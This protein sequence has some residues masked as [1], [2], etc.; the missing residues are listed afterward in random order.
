MNTRLYVRLHRE[1]CVPGARCAWILRDSRGGEL[2]R[3]ESVLTALPAADTV[4]GVLAQDLVLV[5]AVVL[6]PGRR[7]RTAAALASAIE[8]HVLSDPASNHVVVLREARDGSTVLAAMARN[9]LDACLASLGDARRP[10]AKLVLESSLVPRTLQC[11]V[12]VCRADGGFLCLPDEQAVTLDAAADGVLPEGLKWHLQ[13]TV[14]A[15]RP[16]LL[17]VH[18][19][20]QA[21]DVAAW[22]AALG[23]DVERADA[24]DWADATATGAGYDPAQTVDLLA[25]LRR[26]QSAA[27]PRMPY[28]RTPL[29]LAALV[30]VVHVG[31][32][33]TH[34]GLRAAE[35]SRLR[36]DIDAGFRQV[37][38]PNEP[39]VDAVLQTQRTLAAA[40]RAAGQYAPGDFM[41]LL[42]RLAGETANLPPAGLRSVQYS[43]G[44]LTATWNGVPAAALEKSAQQLRSHGL[45]VDVTGTPA[46]MQ[47]I[48]RAQP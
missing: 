30:L 40:R 15:A 7:A 18:H 44:S 32:T 45:R 43:A 16:T 11:W 1:A 41:P 34:Y 19:G 33:L 17:R 14:P 21:F 2:R 39:L 38:G 3:G 29:V 5:R 23:V 28:W 25:A 4:V 12:A 8:P 9:W 10:P 42:A 26:E 31:A 22:Q 6:P 13:S 48:V 24:W 37:A 20:S 35:R 46:Q 47:M 27:E 36:A